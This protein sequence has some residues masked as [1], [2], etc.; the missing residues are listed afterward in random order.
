MNTYSERTEQIRQEFL[1]F[2]ESHRLFHLMEKGKRLMSAQQKRKNDVCMIHN[3]QARSWLEAE[4]IDSSLAIFTGSGSMVTRGILSV[5]TELLSGLSAREVLKSDLKLFSDMGLS[6]LLV[7]QRSGVFHHVIKNVH[8]L[9][10]KEI[11]DY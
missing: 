5:F 10:R 8:D 3:C 4:F 1:S 9:A 6:R 2:P 7:S 11:G